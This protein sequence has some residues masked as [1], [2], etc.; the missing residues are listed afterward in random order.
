MSAYVSA[1]SDWRVLYNEKK[2]WMTRINVQRASFGDA[3]ASAVAAAI[4][5]Q[6]GLLPDNGC[7]PLY[8]CQ[9]PAHRTDRPSTH[10]SYRASMGN[11]CKRQ[12]LRRLPHSSA[13]L[14]RTDTCCVAMTTLQL[15]LGYL[16]SVDLAHR[17][18]RSF[19]P[20]RKWQ[21]LF[22]ENLLWSSHYTAVDFADQNIKHQSQ[23]AMKKPPDFTVIQN[24][25]PIMG[26]L[27]IWTWSKVRHCGNWL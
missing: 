25:Y 27:R 3:A 16:S 22:S 5:M 11:Q 21:L 8:R 15:Y 13:L 17:I 23:K 4:T 24:G 12:S 2:R 20:R 6:R 19:L 10:A 18:G 26:H 7:T 9:Q 1:R 14:Y